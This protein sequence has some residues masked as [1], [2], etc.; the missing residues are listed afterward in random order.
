MHFLNFNI[1]V[2]FFGINILTI[3]GCFTKIEGLFRKT[4][5]LIIDIESDKFFSISF[6]YL[7]P[8]V[9]QILQKMNKQRFNYGFKQNKL[10]LDN[11]SVFANHNIDPKTILRLC[12]RCGAKCG[13]MTKIR[14]IGS[15]GQGNSLRRGSLQRGNSLTMSQRRNLAHSNA[16]HE[17]I[18]GS[19]R[20]N[21]IGSGGGSFN[22][23]SGSFHSHGGSFHNRGGSFLSRSGSFQRSGSMHHSNSV[24]ARQ[25]A[26]FANERPDSEE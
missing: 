12:S 22:R 19:V 26:V 14:F 24:R 15:Q 2:L 5:I 8:N 1:F 25:R 10:M 23:G 21:S 6:L 17:G 3:N 9:F 13:M 4:C 7:K 16:I 11:M 18:Y 20:R